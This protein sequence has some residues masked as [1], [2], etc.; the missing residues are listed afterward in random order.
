MSFIRERNQVPL[1]AEQ[2]AMVESWCD[3]YTS[4]FKKVGLRQ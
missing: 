2:E 3:F 1:T 4:I